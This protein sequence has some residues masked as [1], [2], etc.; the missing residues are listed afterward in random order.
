VAVES[1]TPKVEVL[2]PGECAFRAGGAVRHHGGEAALAGAVASAVGQVLGAP[3]RC[4]IGIADGRFAASLAAR[5]DTA[6]TPPTAGDGRLIVPANGAASFL[7]PFPVQVLERPELVDTFV[8]LGLTTLGHLAA[9]PR[10]T[11]AA[12]FGPEGIRAHRLASG[13]DEYPSAS[14]RP[15]PDL[16]VAAELEPP[17]S[18]VDVA[19]FAAKALADELVERLERLGLICTRLRIEVE[20]EH[21]ETMA[22]VWRHEPAARPLSRRG[23]AS[24][25]RTL[26]AAAMAERVR[27]QLEGWLAGAAAAR[28]TGA[29][30][31]L[32]LVP[33]EVIPAR[34]RQLGFWG[35]E[36]EA[37][38]RAARAL[39]RVQGLL[40]QEAV[41]KI[42]LRGGRGP[43]DQVISMAEGELHHGHALPLAPPHASQAGGPVPPAPKAGK[44]SEAGPEAAP[45]PGRIPEPS[46]AIVHPDPPPAEVQDERGEPVAVSGRGLLS[47]TPSRLRVAAGPWAPIAAWAGPWPVDERWWDP[48]AHQRLARLQVTTD[49]GTAYLLKL[50]GGQWWVEGVYD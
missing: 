16:G 45:W 23:A 18:R 44:A 19:A 27:W 49:A 14:R 22:R 48:R 28:P 11:L 37:S 8:R 30:S 38:R 47:A 4:R 46:P 24:D 10:A 9:L 3:G 15:P 31:R 40:G 29:V 26:Q 5:Y 2:H 41:R 36:T 35:E 50:A 12:R 39:A 6:A 1:L 43:A 7:A 21:G 20:T 34:G 17:A 25:L 13:K 42:S 33:D 32:A